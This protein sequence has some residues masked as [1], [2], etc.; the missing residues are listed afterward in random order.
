MN[1]TTT[2]TTKF[3]SL[4]MSAPMMRSW[5][6]GRKTLTRRIVKPQPVL[7]CGH[8]NE[9]LWAPGERRIIK[10]PHPVGSVLWLRETMHLECDGLWRYSADGE[11]FD[12]ASAHTEEMR[13]WFGRPLPRLPGADE[14][15]AVLAAHVEPMEA[16]RAQIGQRLEALRPPG[17][18]AE[19]FLELPPTREEQD[20]LEQRE[21]L[22][23]AL[24]RVRFF[25]D[26]GD[27]EWIVRYPD[28]AAAELALVPLSV[29]SMARELFSERSRR[30]CLKRSSARAR[31]SC[32]KRPPL[33]AG[34]IDA[35]FC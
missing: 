17:Q 7:V 32:P 5:R 29:A 27:R 12:P 4:I 14:Y 2:T 9:E 35:S 11:V 10:C 24:A 3:G 26:A 25:L 13:D 6:E 8:D 19:L 30:T 21:Q 33:R 31:A 22:E 16:R 34:R 1:D 28:H 18:P 20:L 23:S 15:R